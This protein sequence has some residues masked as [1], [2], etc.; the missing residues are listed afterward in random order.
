MDSAT[1][2][3]FHLLSPI[4]KLDLIGQL[5]DSLPE[6]PAALPTLDWH[7]QELEHRLAEAD[8]TPQAAIPWEEVERRLRERP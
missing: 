4:E 2:D 1:H 8:A 7:R 6:S 5:W 3:I